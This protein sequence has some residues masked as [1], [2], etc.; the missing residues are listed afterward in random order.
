MFFLIYET[1]LWRNT[2][3]VIILAWYVI[4]VQS[5]REFTVKSYI[6]KYFD[7]SR[8][9]CMIPRRKV[10]EKKSGETHNV[11][12][13]L[14][15]GYVFV[16]TTSITFSIY[17]QL[18][19]APYIYKFLNYLNPRDKQISEGSHMNQSNPDS[20]ECPKLRFDDPID[21]A[22]YFQRVSDEEMSTV[23]NLLNHDDVIDYSK[24]YVDGTKVHVV[25]GPLTGK[26][27]IIKKIDKHKK[28]AKILL[29]M[30]NTTVLVDVGIELI[31]SL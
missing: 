30:V 10:P 7:S 29:N 25:S 21:E 20:T 14:Y 27:G 23:L 19:K 4:F 15:P 8:V 11:I 24:I 31:N 28:R 22:L 1:C 12:K 16:Q 17:Y 6:S 2:I 3:E 18:C 9:R 5:G 13:T 26:E